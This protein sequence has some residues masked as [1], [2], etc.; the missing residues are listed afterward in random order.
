MAIFDEV[1]LVFSSVELIMSLAVVF[2]GWNN[3]QTITINEDF[4]F[5]Y[6]CDGAMN[7]YWIVMHEFVAITYINLGLNCQAQV[8]VQ[9]G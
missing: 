4:S 9:V 2:S 8:Q 1:Q 5:F 7:N 6:L 3:L